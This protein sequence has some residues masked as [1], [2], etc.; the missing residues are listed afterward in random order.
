MGETEF[1][2]QFELSEDERNRLLTVVWQPGMSVSCSLYRSNRVTPIYTLLNFTCLLLGS[3]LKRELEEYWTGSAMPDQQFG[4]E[5]ERFGEYLRRRVDS[6]AIKS[7]YL[8][9]VLDFELAMNELQFVSRT[10]IQEQL[11]SA[12]TEE[13]DG[14]VRL[15]PLMRVVR[16]KHEPFEV[17]ARLREED[18]P[19]DRC[20]R[21]RLRG[22]SE[23]P[24]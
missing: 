8:M 17:L 2:D 18:L 5:I 20:D 7:A 13:P 23:C 3:D 9:E 14:S 24:F 11:K 4:P 1:L 12:K 16:F 22:C 19:L 15:H 6:G 10:Q 21:G